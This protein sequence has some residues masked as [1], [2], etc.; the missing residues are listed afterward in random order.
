VRRFLGD[1]QPF[2]SKGSA[3]SEQAELGMAH[4]EPG[5][6]DHGGQ[7]K[8]VEALVAPRPIEG[9]HRRVNRP[10]IVAL[11]LIGLA[12]VLVCPQDHIPASRIE[13]ALGGGDGLVIRAHLVAMVG[14]KE[15]DPSQPAR[16]VERLGEGLGL[17]QSRQDTPHIA[18]RRERRAR[19]EPQIDGLLARGTRLWQ[20]RQGAERLLEIRYGLAVCRPR[21]GLLPGLPAVV[22]GVVPHLPLVEVV[23]QL[24]VVLPQPVRV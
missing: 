21:Q 12:E 16:V 4:G 22:E 17:A 19:V 10:T 13:R 11:G 7:E 3:L 6:G 24:R 1:P 5:Q 15:Q 9:G 2:F 18:R 8:L 20:M 23:C 14:Q